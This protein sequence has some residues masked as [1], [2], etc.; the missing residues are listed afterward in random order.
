MNWLPAKVAV[1]EKL[2]KCLQGDLR[3]Q[4]LREELYRSLCAW[5]RTEPLLAVSN[6][7]LALIAPVA[8]AKFSA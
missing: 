6:R 5:I 2:E 4:M 1:L 3:E 7:G 8:S